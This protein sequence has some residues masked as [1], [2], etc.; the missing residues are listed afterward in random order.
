MRL[1]FTGTRIGMTDAQL[2]GLFGLMIRAKRLS[3]STVDFHH[4][5][6]VGSDEQAHGLARVLGFRICG[7]PP[8]DSRFTMRYSRVE[9]FRLSSPREYLLRNQ[10]IVDASDELIAAPGESEEV[11]RSGTWATIRR[12]RSVERRHTIVFPNGALEIKR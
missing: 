8:R 6:C 3:D 12:A 7:H 1:G 10:D 2:A 9:F 11:Q 5:L 4:G